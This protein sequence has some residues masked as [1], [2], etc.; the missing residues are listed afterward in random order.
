MC[1]VRS[2]YYY[3]FKQLYGQC[4]LSWHARAMLK[5]TEVSYINLLNIKGFYNVQRYSILFY[6]ENLDEILDWPVMQFIH[7]KIHDIQLDTAHQK[8]GL[9]FGRSVAQSLIVT[10]QESVYIQFNL[11]LYCVFK[12]YV[13]G[14]TC[15]VIPMLEK[16]K[17]AVTFLLDDGK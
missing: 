15:S 11:K 8:I 9:R 7:E 3:L 17:R 2:K 1:Y 4:C 12:Y 16:R 13:F 10:M 14:V 6:Y 5:I